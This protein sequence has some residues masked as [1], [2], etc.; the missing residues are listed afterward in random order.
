M[1]ARFTLPSAFRV[2][3]DASLMVRMVDTI[4][5]NS[6]LLIASSWCTLSLSVAFSIHLAP[7][8]PHRIR[9]TSD[10][11]ASLPS[12]LLSSRLSVANLLHANSVCAG[13]STTVGHHQ[14]W[15][16]VVFRILKRYDPKHHG[17]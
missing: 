16:D 5:M 1:V 6:F 10:G 8:S 17:P 7:S 9:A 14:Q 12:S 4:L 13:S 15:G 3:S 2:L 11:P